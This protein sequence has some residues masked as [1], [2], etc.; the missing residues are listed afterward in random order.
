MPVAVRGS[1]AH[2]ERAS[3]HGSGWDRFSPGF[4]SQGGGG[5]EG[6]GGEMAV[7]ATEEADSVAGGKNVTT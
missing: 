1:R 6:G 4:A 3:A 5:G 7:G 2:G